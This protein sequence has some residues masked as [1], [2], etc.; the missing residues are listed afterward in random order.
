MRL[1]AIPLDAMTPA[2]RA[3][4]DATVS[5]P[6]GRMVPPVAAWLHAPGVAGPAQLLGQHIR[7]DSSLPPAWN[8][9][10]ILV[11]ARHWGASYEWF[12]HKRMALEAGLASEI[13]EAILTRHPPALPA[14][15][16]AI[17][18]YATDLLSKRNVSMERHAAMV[19]HWG[20][21]GVVDLVALLGYYTLVSMTLNAFDVG[22]PAG[23]TAEVLPPSV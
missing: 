11:V 17:Y 18:E 5:G 1:P 7:Y 23:E 2:Q 9:M 4:Y 10:A 13:V 20:T 16:M 22:L 6:R 15:A 14:E 12:A 21:Q 8:E 3:V 19:A